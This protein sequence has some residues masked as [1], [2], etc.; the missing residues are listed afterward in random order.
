MADRLGFPLAFLA[1]ALLAMTVA[2]TIGHCTSGLKFLLH[3]KIEKQ[4]IHQR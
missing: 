2:L 3:R 1:A 4:Y